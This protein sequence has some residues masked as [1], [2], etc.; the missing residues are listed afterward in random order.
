MGS[1]MG[2]N[3]ESPAGLPPEPT[4]ILYADPVEGTGV[5]LFRRVCEMDLRESL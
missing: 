4:Q 3:F 1:E 2:Q 5:D